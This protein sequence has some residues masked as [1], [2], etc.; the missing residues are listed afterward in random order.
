MDYFTGI[1][2]GAIQGLTEFLPISSSGHL[3]LAE[4]ILGGKAST[5]LIFEVMVHFATMVAVV[6]FFR[7]KIWKMIVSLVPP[8]TQDKLPALKLVAIIIIGTIPAGVIGLALENYIEG[9]FSST[10]V[11]SIMLLV[12]GMILLSTRLIKSGSNLPNFKTGLLIG[13]AQ[14]AALMPG[15]SRS[16]TTIAAGLHLKLAPSEAAEFSFLLSLPA[17]FGA[18]LLKSFDLI[19]SPI[20]G[21]AIGPYVAGAITAFIIGY[22]SIAWLMRI[23]KRGK[24]FFFGIYCLLIGFLGLVLL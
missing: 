16:G 15:I 5:G 20:S 9:A 6:L 22:L 12:T 11:V 10:K 8:Y 3:V 1:I 14:S 2:L 17:V 13:I 24:F 4:R 7:E 23:I 18:T 19:G 21:N